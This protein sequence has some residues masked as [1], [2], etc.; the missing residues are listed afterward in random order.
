LIISLLGLLGIFLLPCFNKAIYNQ[1][2]IALTALA[3]GTLF[4]DAALH[5]LPVVSQNLFKGYY[6]VLK[7][8]LFNVDFWNRK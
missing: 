2:I 6:Y 8:I 4:S 3:I 5:L 7:L 1:I